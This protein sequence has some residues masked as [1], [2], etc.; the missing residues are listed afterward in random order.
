MKCILEG[1][2]IMFLG[3]LLFFFF[4]FFFFSSTEVKWEEE[5]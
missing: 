3:F 1:I 2:F 5:P 4:F